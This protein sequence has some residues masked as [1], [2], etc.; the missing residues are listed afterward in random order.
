MKRRRLFKRS[1]SIV[2]G[3]NLLSLFLVTWFATSSFR[4][5][6]LDHTVIE[7]E[8]SAKLIQPLFQDR[9]LAGDQEAVDQLCKSLKFRNRITVILPDGRVWGD[10]HVPVADMENHADR[11]EFQEALDQGQGESIR[12]SE[13]TSRKFIYFAEPIFHRDRVLAVLRLSAPLDLVESTLLDIRFN[14]MLAWI[15]MSLLTTAAIMLFF[16]WLSKPLEVLRTDAERFAAGNFEGALPVP[17]WEEIGDLAQAMNKMALRLDERSLTILQQRMEVEAILSSMEEAV[18]AV[19]SQA[20]ILKLNQAMVDLFRLD[21][22]GSRGRRVQEVIRN[23]KFIRFVSEALTRLQ[24]TD[25]NLTIYNPEPVYLLARATRLRDGSGNKVGAVVVLNNITEIR[26]L[27][28]VRKEFVANVSHELRTPITSIKG[29]VETLESGAIDD[30][31]DAHHFLG[32]IARQTDRLG[33]IIE[34]LLTLSKIESGQEEIKLGME[35]RNIRHSLN[36]VVKNA[37]AQAMQRQIQVI[38]DC[39][40]DLEASIHPNLL[41]QAVFNLLDN[42]IKYSNPKSKVWIRAYMEKGHKVRID[43]NDEGRGIPGIHLER[44]FERFYRVDTARSRDMGGTGLGLSIVKHIVQ[45]H[46]GVVGVES[47]V[48]EGSRFSIQIPA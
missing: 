43:V 45:A 30:R 3:V 6:H 44:L 19:D 13:S 21:P 32:I 41:E 25:T 37:E 29:F 47:E 2:I 10:S 34:D 12:F 24:P 38:V 33:N 9:I 5:F 16:R 42:A 15:F 17:H 27:E 20:C 7:L 8:N 23:Q 26:R 31:D 14:I 39:S 35:V 48:D 40:E 46:N 18:M 1:L 11:V 28:N 22:Q 36:R 4:Q